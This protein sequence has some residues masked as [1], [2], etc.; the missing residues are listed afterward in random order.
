MST[1]TGR[2]ICII[3]GILAIIAGVLISLQASDLWP[4]AIGIPAAIGGVLGIAAALTLGKKERV[5]GALL[6]GAAVASFVCL[7][8]VS[9]IAFI[10]VRVYGFHSPAYAGA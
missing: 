2:L 8:L 5:S 6:V 10:V 4:L 1:K 7:N 9:A 3:A